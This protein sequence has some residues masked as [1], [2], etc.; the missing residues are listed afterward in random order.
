MKLYTVVYL[1]KNEKILMLYRNKKVN[2]INYGKWLGVGGHIEEY[3][4]PYECAVRE[5]KEETGYTVNS[6]DYRGLITF[7]L[8][9]NETEYIFVF[10]SKDFSGNQIE[11]NEG[12]LHWVDKEDLMN[13]NIWESDYDFIEKIKNDDMEL[14]MLKNLYK[15]M[16]LVERRLEI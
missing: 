5:V 8:D 1:I 9:N 11:C 10:S 4:S 13:L 12:E 2:D 15:N 3:E 16:K 14:F 7:I 6:L